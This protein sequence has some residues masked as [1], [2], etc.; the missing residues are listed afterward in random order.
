MVKLSRQPVSVRDMKAGRMGIALRYLDP[1]EMLALSGAW[2]GQH[3]ATLEGIAELS[4][5]L[6]RLEEAHEALRGSQPSPQASTDRLRKVLAEA[7]EID[8]RHDHAVRSLHFAL[9][10]AIEHHLS[11]E[12]PDID[13]ITHIEVLRDLVLPD[14]LATTQ[15]SYESEAGMAARAAEAVASDRQAQRL[16]EKIHVLA[17][18]TGMDLLATWSE[19]GSRLGALEIERASLSDGAQGAPRSSARARN[20]WLSIVATMLSVADHSSARPEALAAFRAP[21]EQACAA[22]AQRHAAER[23]LASPA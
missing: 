3:R 13:L 22:A 7:R 23:K 2:L 1:A 21:L 8:D 6:F 19:L 20:G 12:E 18:V 11:Q 16:L 14:G 9:S 15:A 10:A 17:R 5:L 4:P